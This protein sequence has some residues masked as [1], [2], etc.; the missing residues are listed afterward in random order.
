MSLTV[1]HDYFTE[2]RIIMMHQH[3]KENSKVSQNDSSKQL[4]GT[5]NYKT[6]EDAYHSPTLLIIELKVK[7]NH[8]IPVLKIK[9]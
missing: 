3:N 4:I 6:F 1:D 8:K 7:I 9:K 2:Q 5:K